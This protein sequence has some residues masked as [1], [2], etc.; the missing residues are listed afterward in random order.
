MKIGDIPRN[1][2]ARFRQ[3]CVIPALPL[4]LDRRRRFSERHQ[5]AGLKVAGVCGRTLQALREATFA[6][7]CGYHAYPH[8]NDAAFV[9][10]NR[11]RW[12]AD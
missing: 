4:A 7:A 11:D 8:L 6:R 9:K 5:R 2:L 10:T 1:V 12:L 3:G